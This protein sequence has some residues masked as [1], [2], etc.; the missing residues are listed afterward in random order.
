[1]INTP[2]F[3]NTDIAFLEISQT[4]FSLENFYRKLSVAN[5]SFNEIGR[6][7]SEICLIQ[8]N[9]YDIARAVDELSRRFNIVFVSGSLGGQ[10]C[11][12][13]AS[14]ISNVFNVPLEIS[15][16]AMA[17]Y[18][19]SL[20]KNGIEYVASFTKKTLFPRNSAILH[21]KDS[22]YFGFRFANIICVDDSLQC[23][24]EVLEIL[25][26]DLLSGCNFFTRQIVT[27]IP[28]ELFSS[29][30]EEFANNTDFEYCIIRDDEN[31]HKIVIHHGNISQLKVY[32]LEICNILQEIDG[33]FKVFT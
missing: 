10:N 21:K 16:D 9:K 31:S 27:K 4:N 23:A 32:Y 3:H 5:R 18:T 26:K 13:I 7:I 20:Q 19:S 12:H 14:I 24:S 15:P 2:K 1:M 8:N 29:K 6:R 30:I 22:P 33:T 11:H 17:I 25:Q 28:I